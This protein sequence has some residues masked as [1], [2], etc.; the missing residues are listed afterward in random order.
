MLF[1]SLGPGCSSMTGLLFELGPCSIANEGKN[2][3]RNPYSW[4]ESANV[5]FLDSPTGVGYSY[6]GKAVSNSH[7]TALDI[8]AFFQVSST[9]LTRD[10]ACLRLTTFHPLTSAALLR[11]VPQV[12]ESSFP[13]LWRVLRRYLPPQHRFSDP[14]TQSE[15]AHS[16][17]NHDSP[18]IR[19]DR[20]RID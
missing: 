8:Y 15:E 12:P 2:T 11:K 17:G 9:F 18:R 4:T 6:G 3:T 19:P 16:L 5:V 1:R 20:K 7:D 14:P 13:R 10:A